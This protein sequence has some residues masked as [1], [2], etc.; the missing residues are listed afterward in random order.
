MRLRRSHVGMTAGTTTE[1]NLADYFRTHGI[2]FSPVLI[3]STE[4]LRGAFLAG[5]CDALTGDTS[6]LAVFRA[7][8][9]ID[10]VVQRITRS[11]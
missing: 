4:E 6:T 2:R 9:P 10:D 7:G 3:E 8:Q 11:L 5:R 1:Q